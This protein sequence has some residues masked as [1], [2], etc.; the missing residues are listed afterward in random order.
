VF[1]RTSSSIKDSSP[2]ISPLVGQPVNEMKLVGLSAARQPSI[3]TRHYRPNQTYR[4]LAQ[5]IVQHPDI[6]K[7]VVS[8]PSWNQP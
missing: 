6:L 5:F 2:S 7:A 1:P 4:L 3:V 8:K